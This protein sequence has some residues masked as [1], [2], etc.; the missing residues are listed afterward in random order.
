MAFSTFALS[1][2]WTN[3]SDFPTYEENEEQ[4]REDMQCLF[5]EL[6]DGLNKLI[7]EL[8]KKTD[9][10][11]AKGIGISPLTGALAGYENVEDALVA[12]E[13]AIQGVVLDQVPDGSIT[14]IKLGPSAVT[15]PKVADGAITKPKLAAGAV[16]NTKCDFTT[17]LTV[18]GQLS[19]QGAVI[20]G[21]DCYGDYDDLPAPGTPGRLF[22]VKVGSNG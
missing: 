20:I 12:L 5:D 10:S 4:V 8:K 22:F 6:S 1:K 11:G 14:T 13:T 16:D 2:D 17:G 18:A 21:S 9:E 15:E 7:T 19:A 3:P